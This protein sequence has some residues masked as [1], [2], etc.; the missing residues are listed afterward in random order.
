L[1]AK[2]QPKRIAR[3]IEDGLLGVELTAEGR[4]RTERAL[5]TAV[6]EELVRDGRVD[7]ERIGRM[8]RSRVVDHLIWFSRA[9]LLGQL[10]ILFFVLNAYLTSRYNTQLA[11]GGLD[12]VFIGAIIYGLLLSV[13]SIAILWVER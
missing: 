11:L 3:G 6:V 2:K 4:R 5:I 9:L 7:R 13:L 12:S 8:V 10:S 1:D